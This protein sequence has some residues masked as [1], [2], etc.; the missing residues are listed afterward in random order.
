MATSLLSLI[1]SS[2][3]GH[4]DVTWTSH[5][6]VPIPLIGWLV[7]WYMKG[8]YEVA[9]GQMLQNASMTFEQNEKII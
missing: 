7:G 8:E 4:T 1:K 6:D 3:G 2:S 5:Y 9:F